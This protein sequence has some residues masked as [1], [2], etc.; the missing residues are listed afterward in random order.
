MERQKTPSV[1]KSVEQLELS[2]IAG[3]SINLYKPLWEIVKEYLLKLKISLRYNPTV[4]FLGLYAT[5]MYT[6]VHQKTCTGIFIAAL[7]ITAKKILE[8]N[9]SV[10]QK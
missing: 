2:Y 3:G 5:D 8:N 9:L 1:S 7:F 6:R 4:S 10:H